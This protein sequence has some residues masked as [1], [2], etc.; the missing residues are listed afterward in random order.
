[1]CRP[2]RAPLPEMPTSKGQGAKRAFVATLKALGAKYGVAVTV[3][4]ASSDADVRRAHKRVLLKVHP[5][6][7]GTAT[8]AQRLQ[9]AREAWDSAAKNPVGGR[10]QRTPARPPQP[11]AAAHG[12][13]V[14]A[15]EAGTGTQNSQLYRIILLRLY[16]RYHLPQYNH[17]LSRP[18]QSLCQ[19]ISRI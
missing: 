5:D 13:L 16:W 1:M 19:T 11:S 6:K 15:G 14:V 17:Y 18:R 10:P 12:A 9:A 4:R 8:D 7:G 2:R 3:S